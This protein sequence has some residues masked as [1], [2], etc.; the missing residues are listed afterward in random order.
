MPTE[1]NPSVSRHTEFLTTLRTLFPHASGGVAE[2]C[3]L[4]VGGTNPLA[5]GG[6][7]RPDDDGLEV[8]AQNAAAADEEGMNVYFGLNLRDDAQL[9]RADHALESGVRGRDSVVTRRQWLLVDADPV[10]AEGHGGE[11]STREEKKA[12]KELISTMIRWLCKD[13]QWPRPAVLGDSGNGYHALWAISL[14]AQDNGLVSACLRALAHKFDNATA[15]ID[16]AVCDPSRICRLYGSVNRKGVPTPERPHRTSKVLATNDRVPVE[17]A[18]L[19]ALASEAPPAASPKRVANGKKTAARKSKKGQ[20]S[21][22][23][24]ARTWVEAQPAACSGEGGHNQTFAVACGLVVDYGLCEDDAYTLLAEYNERCEPP[25]NERELDHKLQSAVTK[26]KEAPARVGRKATTDSDDEKGKGRASDYDLLVALGESAELWCSPSGDAYAT[27]PVDDHSEHLPVESAQFEDWLFS[28]FRFAY[29]RTPKTEPINQASKSLASVARTGKVVHPVYIRVG[30]AD[31][32]VWVDLCGEKWQAV[33]ITTAGWEVVAKPTVRFAR[34]SLMRALPTPQ[35][36]GSLAALRP[37]LNVCDED[38]PT[39]LAFLVG[40]FLGKGTFPILCPHGA[41]GSGKSTLMRQV[42]ELIDPRNDSASTGV[43]ANNDALMLV[44]EASWLQPFNNATK[45]TVEQ[46]NTLCT[47]VEGASL[48]KR[49][50]YSNK[51][52]TVVSARR[53]AI[54]NGVSLVPDQTDLLSRCLPIG[55]VAREE[56]QHQTEEALNASLAS[57][58]PQ[59]TGGLYTAVSV[60]L[61]RFASVHLED[62]P[63]L[64]DFARWATA[65]EPA[66]ELPEGTVVL[67][68]GRTRRDSSAAA[69][70]ASPLPTVIRLVLANHDGEWKATTSEWLAALN[71]ALAAA[72]N[73]TLRHTK[74]WPK[75]ARELGQGLAMLSPDL[76]SAGLVAKF[77]RGKGVRRWEISVVGVE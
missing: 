63:R 3:V 75:D 13:R 74:G 21:A 35:Q 22:L 25:W 73:T 56:G 69:I 28:T 8:M 77:S 68:L 43:P 6:F 66:L 31:G 26:A 53:P 64:H 4:Q 45:L 70:E 65:A 76:A 40:C 30:W 46:S 37:L 32:E 44:A 19:V 1:T 59:V 14:A 42:S 15:N 12:A 57:V 60:A 72:N 10:K 18:L 54:L 33:R 11:A 34:N 49:T 61:A 52:L 55:L 48:H 51:G 36:G 50:H 5:S 24:Q 58:L 2:L 29:G 7:F 17:P 9:S 62:P 67:A 20:G 23:D 39:V 41:A 71:A 38:Y 27:V 16:T 47:L